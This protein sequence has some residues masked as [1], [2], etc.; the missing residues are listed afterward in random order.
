MS[1]IMVLWKR[2]RTVT[3]LILIQ[4]LIA[5]FFIYAA[6]SLPSIELKI[7]TSSLAIAFASIA[8]SNMLNLSDKQKSNQIL[9]KLNRIEDLQKELNNEEIESQISDQNDCQKV[10]VIISY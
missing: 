9:D 8:S 7:G 3:I 10:M 2:S 5:L 6:L 1:N 4:W